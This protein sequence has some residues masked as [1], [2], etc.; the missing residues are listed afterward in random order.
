LM[1]CLLYTTKILSMTN[2][3]DNIPLRLFVQDEYYF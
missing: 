2:K 3:Q 1:P